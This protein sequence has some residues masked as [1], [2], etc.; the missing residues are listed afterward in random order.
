MRPLSELPYIEWTTEAGEAK[1]IYADVW[2][3]EEVS[4]PAVITQHAVESSAKVSDHY[5]KDPRTQTVELYFSGS[6]I[7]GDL[8]PENPGRERAVQLDYPG[9]Y[10]GPSGLRAVTEGVK[11]LFGGGAPALPP[12]VSVLQFA[13]P[14]AGRLAKVLTQLDA[15]QGK[16]LIT[17]GGS[18]LRLENMG[19]ANARGHRDDASGDGGTVAL[20]LEQVTFTKSDVAVAVP[21]P[22]EARAQPKKNANSGDP[23]KV[24]GPKSSAAKKLTDSAGITDA[25]SGI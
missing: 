6:P 17:V 24:E 16:T 8:D 25:G 2:R 9:E 5:R 3:S 15:L 20:E 4:L 22:I 13:Q 12:S 23:S 19:I 21:L 18:M 7:R 10:R 11:S 1:R 14:P